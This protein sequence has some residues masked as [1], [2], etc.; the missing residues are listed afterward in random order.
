MVDK[1]TTIR[2]D[3]KTKTIMDNN[4]VHPRETY[5]DLIKRLIKKRK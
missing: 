3:K 5:D 1:T 2:I 4:K